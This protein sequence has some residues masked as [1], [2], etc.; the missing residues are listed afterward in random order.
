[1]KK[2]FKILLWV[3]ASYYLSTALVALL[4]I[5]F[6]MQITGPKTD[7]WLVKTVSVLLIP[8]SLCLILNAVVK[9]NPLPVIAV[10]LSSSLVLA[11][12]DFYYTANDTIK[13][14]YAV[15][16]ILQ[17]VFVTGWTIILFKNAQLSTSSFSNKI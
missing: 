3:Q 9:T 16:G 11:F 17:L 8:I 5:H 14:V 13:W 2:F 4:D 1:V 7:I 12:I 6:F 10:G 15:D